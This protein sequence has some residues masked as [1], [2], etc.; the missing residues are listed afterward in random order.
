MHFKNIQQ[1]LLEELEQAAFAE[2]DWKAAL[3]YL[4]SVKK[5]YGI[6]GRK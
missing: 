6:P 4:G 3:S 1:N 5:E 2:N